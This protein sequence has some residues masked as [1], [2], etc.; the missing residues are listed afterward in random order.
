MLRYLP[1]G[2]TVLVEA[3]DVEG[4]F[5]P[6]PEPLA[7]DDLRPGYKKT[8]LNFIVNPLSEA[9]KENDIH[10]VLLH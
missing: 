1:I 10:N 6:E 3:F 2:W 7:C 9:N 8:Q 5:L 4:A